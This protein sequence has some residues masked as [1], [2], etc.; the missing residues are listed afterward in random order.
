MESRGP[1]VEKLAAP[2]PR[3]KFFGNE[4]MKTLEPLSSAGTERATSQT[5]E[6]GLL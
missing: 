2:R 6:Q 5:G 4:P 3:A 1:V